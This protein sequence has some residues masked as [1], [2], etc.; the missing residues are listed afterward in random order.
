MSYRSAFFESVAGDRKYTADRWAQIFAAIQST[1]YIPGYAN[2]MTV[3]EDVPAAMSVRINT[4]AGFVQGR[5]VEIYAT[6]VLAL[7]AAHAT[8]Y[9]R[10]RVILRLDLSSGVRDLFPVIKQ[11]AY[12]ATSGAAANPSLQQDATI[13]EVSLASILV[14]PT[15]TSITNS[16]ITDERDAQWGR[17]SIPDLVV[18][19][20]ASTLDHPD[21]SVID[22]K[23]GNR[24]ATNQGY[25]PTNFG[26]DT[27][28]GWINRFISCIQQIKGTTNFWETPPQSLTALYTGKVAKSGDTMTGNLIA[29]SV[30]W[31]SNALRT[32]QPASSDFNQ[33]L[34]SG[35]Y[36]LNN[37]A[38]PPSASGGNWYLLNIRHY[39][40]GNHYA[41]QQAWQQNNPYTDAWM[42]NVV[43]GSYQGWYKIWNGLNDGAGSGMD[44]DFLRGIAPGNSS[45]NIPV[46][47]GSVVNNLN[48]EMVGG[49]FANNA[50]NQL[51][52]LNGS[53]RAT[54][55]QLLQGFGW[56]PPVKLQSL[57]T[58]ALT[59]GNLSGATGNVV[60]AGRY[61]VRAYVA[62]GTTNSS[63]GD[64]GQSLNA[65][66]YGPSG[67]LGPTMR[68][69]APSGA[70]DR[71][72]THAIE[73]EVVLA[74]SAPLV[75]YVNKSGGSGNSQHR[76]SQIVAEWKAPS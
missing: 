37:P 27:L 70:E 26:P 10:D 52:I 3:V 30:F 25:F 58:F 35:F 21:N 51:A 13:W 69:Y 65:M 24:T 76:Y 14:V 49:K 72:W 73:E 50:A 64:A 23:I 40:N 11:G 12:A 36:E 31:G 75:I 22:S 68:S 53:G 44:T 8:Q 56:V 4:G 19:K 48:S 66:L 33:A 46:A 60:S 74:A 61:L 57:S 28:L 42:R 39:D 62:L 63:A 17:A 67:Q 15:D 2:S 59:T 45:G 32:E 6:H 71:Q 41:F 7:A 29:P 54:D 16:E 1:G 9:R 5:F 47:N 38:N 55:A 18:H 43:N 34:P 20:A